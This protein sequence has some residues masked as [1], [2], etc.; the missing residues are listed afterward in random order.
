MKTFSEGDRV[1]ILKAPEGGYPEGVVPPVFTG[2]VLGLA[3]D[4]DLGPA[5]FMALMAEYPETDI[6]DM[7]GIQLTPIPNGVHVVMETDLDD[8]APILARHPHYYVRVD[9][10]AEGDGPSH[11]RPDELELAKV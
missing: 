5:I 11:F 6:A 2:T 9:G 8:V 3:A 7:P 10:A 1:V 4:L